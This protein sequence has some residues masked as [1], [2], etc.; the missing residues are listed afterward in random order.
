MNNTIKNILLCFT[1]LCVIFL[2]FFCVELYMINADD[3][4]GDL[5]SSAVATNGNLSSTE[6]IPDENDHPAGGADSSQNGSAEVN[7]PDDVQD[8]SEPTDAID[9]SP[10]ATRYSFLLSVDTGARLVLYA[11]DAL[12]DFREIEGYAWIFSY[13]A[14]GNAQLDISFVTVQPQGGL[15][16]LAPNY[17]RNFLSDDEF[18]VEGERRIA[19]SSITGIY[20]IGSNGI[21]NY[22]AWLSDITD[23]GV[24]RMALG[25]VI[26]YENDSQRDMLYAILDTMEISYEEEQINDD[27]L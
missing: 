10:E 17:L 3:D 25:F 4:D 6:D 22:E 23:L 16:E 9:P 5:Q 14:G 19:R 21:D 1:L 12:F 2:V 15:I 8:N 7:Q 24:D 26:N 11:D 20:S 13:Q 18:T 27:D